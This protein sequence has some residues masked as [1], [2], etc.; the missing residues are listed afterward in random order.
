MK[1]AAQETEELDT[2]GG[3]GTRELKLPKREARTLL[4]VGFVLLFALRSLFGTES[5]CNHGGA[6]DA[7]SGACFYGGDPKAN[8]SAWWT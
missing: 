8:C 6:L 2:A 4:V 1:F 5:A 3:E 7:A